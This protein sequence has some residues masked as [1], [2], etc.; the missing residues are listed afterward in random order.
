MMTAWR[1]LNGLPKSA[2]TS[3]A[4]IEGVARVISGAVSASLAVVGEAVTPGVAAILL[5]E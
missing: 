3:L 4:A 5:K 2:A 1:M